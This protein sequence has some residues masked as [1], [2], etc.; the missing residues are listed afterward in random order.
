MAALLDN[1]DG[2]GQAPFVMDDTPDMMTIMNDTK[3]QM[4]QLPDTPFPDLVGQHS[5]QEFHHRE[6]TL[7]GKPI[8]ALSTPHMT[9][10]VHE[11]FEDVIIRLPRRPLDPHHKE[12]SKILEDDIEQDLAEELQKN[13]RCVY[14]FSFILQIQ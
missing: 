14:T 9:P 7:T 4:D 3:K 11:D 12:L 1:F 13:G 10:A 6:N 5:V 8:T 2:G